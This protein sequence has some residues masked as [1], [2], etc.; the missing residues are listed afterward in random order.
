MCAFS[1]CVSW[2]TQLRMLCV[3]LCV[4]ASLRVPDA[5]VGRCVGDG[6]GFMAL[7]GEDR[8]KIK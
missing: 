4:F 8:G 7:W 3:C 1:V 2:C 5:R 6:L